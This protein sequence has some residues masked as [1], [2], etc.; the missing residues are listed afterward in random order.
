MFT[1]PRL[2]SLGLI[3]RKTRCAIAIVI[4]I[5]SAAAVAVPV[6]GSA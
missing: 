5:A 2:V 4:A 3:L 1:Y 6:D